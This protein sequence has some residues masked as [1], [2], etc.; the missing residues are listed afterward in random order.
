MND[1][2][3]GVGF[4]RRA[5]VAAALAAVALARPFGAA[6]AFISQRGMVGGGL[7]KFEGG[8]ANFSL[9]ASK[10]TFPDD[11]EVVVGS[12]LWVATGSGLT[13]ASTALTDYENLA[14]QEKG[15]RIRGTLTSNGVGA[16]PFML[17]VIDGGAPGSGK[18]SIA[19]TVG[20]FVTP[21]AGEAAGTPSGFHYAAVG[22]LATGDLQDLDIDIP[23]P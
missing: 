14:G 11:R 10:L 4:S 5:G 21:A 16:F 8:D 23:E 19:L 17:D 7:V 22:M 12:L 13:L 3:T 15:K 1:S 20:D 9:L 18:D 2:T 6:A